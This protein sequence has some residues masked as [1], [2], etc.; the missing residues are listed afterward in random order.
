V[1]WLADLREKIRE[2]NAARERLLDDEAIR[3]AMYGPEEEDPWARAAIDSADR[4]DE[5]RRAE[6]K[7]RRA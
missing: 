5:E 4:G 7:N 2:S 6:R 3:A 1:K